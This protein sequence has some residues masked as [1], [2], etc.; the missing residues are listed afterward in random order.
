MLV[1]ILVWVRA[2]REQRD[3]SLQHQ[4]NESIPFCSCCLEKKIL[5]HSV[6]TTS[7]KKR[8]SCHLL[9]SEQRERFG[10]FWR[11]KGGRG[12]GK[13]GPKPGVSDD[14]QQE[15]N[16]RYAQRDSHSGA[17]FSILPS[18]SSLFSLSIYMGAWPDP[19]LY[20][21]TWPD[22]FLY[23][24]SFDPAKRR[25][26]PRHIPHQRKKSSYKWEKRSTQ[27]RKEMPNKWEKGTL[28]L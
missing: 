13:K 4:R 17:P 23:I 19:L 8:F 6:P 11:K 12:R 18:L 5:C 2:L 22:P 26:G 25:L 21:L 15:N 1:F 10:F 3:H 28:G 20:I 24:L 14:M 16:G 7:Q 9:G 27:K